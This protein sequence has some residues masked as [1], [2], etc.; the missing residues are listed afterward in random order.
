LIYLIILFLLLNQ[1]HVIAEIEKNKNR[2][3]NY[4]STINELK[5]IYLNGSSYEMGY[6]HGLILKNQ[7]SENFRAQMEICNHL[8]YNYSDILEIWNIMLEFLPQEYLFE[9]LGLADGANISFE[10]V[11]ILNTL[12]AIFNI[13]YSC[14]EISMWGSATNNG[15]LYHIRS[16]D[17]NLNIFDPQSKKYLQENLVIFIRNPTF[18]YKSMNLGFAGNIYC[19]D[20]INEHGIVI[21][22]TSVITNDTTFE[23]INAGFRMRMVLDYANSYN[24]AIEIMTSNRTCGW[25]FVISDSKIPIGY[26]LEQTASCY[27]NGTWNNSIESLT[28]FWQIK[29]TVRR[30]PL[31]ISPECASIETNRFFY[32][33]SNLLSLIYLIQGKSN[34]FGIWT[35]YKALSNEIEKRYGKLDLNESMDL[36]RDEY[37]GKTDIFMFIINRILNGYKPLYQWVACPETGYFIFS[38]ATSNKYAYMTPVHIINLNELWNK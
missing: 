21:G 38:V 20:G 7:I 29:D 31:F 4:F 17:W 27:Y 6:Q 8:G 36:L 12:P 14:C 33:P 15:E 13:M 1:F 32:D 28:P 10:K 37:L 5:I 19:W 25:N 24:E 30:T 22:E 34:L 3:K 2:E 11:A 23:G 18:G 16:F 35:H 26:A 9:M